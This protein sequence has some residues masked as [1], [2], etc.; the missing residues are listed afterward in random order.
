MNSTIKC[1]VDNMQTM[2]KFEAD[3]IDLPNFDRV[4]KIHKHL[5]KEMN[6]LV[7][8][9]PS[10]DYLSFDNIYDWED[11]AELEQ[12]FD[13][14]CELGFN[15]DLS[16]HIAG[17]SRMM[18]AYAALHEV[19]VGYDDVYLLD[20]ILME[21]VT[22]FIKGVP[23]LTYDDATDEDFDVTKKNVR[24]LFDL[25]QCIEYES[26][27]HEDKLSYYTKEQNNILFKFLDELKNIR[28]S[29]REDKG[30]RVTAKLKAFDL[31][32][33]ISDSMNPFPEF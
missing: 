31:R 18:R 6:A 26:H 22:F 19:A 8:N 2:K 15:Q 16:A 4:S 5:I 21:R 14:L 3:D 23:M 29:L 24:E 1:I 9:M 11:V 20:D 7:K 12:D 28:E 30:Y 27:Y 17:S 25:A 33:I 32:H 10:N 13:T